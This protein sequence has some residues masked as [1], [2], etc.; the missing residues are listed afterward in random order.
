MA[1]GIGLHCMY[2]DHGPCN[3]DCTGHDEPTEEPTIKEIREKKINQIL[4]NY[5]EIEG[6]L[7][8]LALDGKFDVI[9]HGCNCLSK[10]GAG[11]AP[12][13]AQTFGCDKFPME[14]MGPNINKLG[15]ID[16]K[17]I[18]IESNELIVVNSYTQYKYGKN[19]EDGDKK[20][21]DYEALTLCMR[22]INQTFKGKRIG[23]PKIGSGLAGG[24]WNQIK[25]I[26][27]T[28]LKDCELT[29]VIYNPGI[30][31]YLS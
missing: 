13:M 19:H 1:I 9:T 29:V 17:T 18:N 20:P 10:M 14:L 27:K 23:L 4:S 25:Q 3:G 21:L 11:I 12:Q 5:T 7:I 22:K 31:L 26:I 8:K 16:Y 30:S 28:E 2:C 24:D 6:D 15:C